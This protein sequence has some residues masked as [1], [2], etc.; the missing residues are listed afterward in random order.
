M[1]PGPVVTF[2]SATA[3]RNFVNVVGAE[4]AADLLRATEVACIGPTTAEAAAQFNIR[5]TIV[6]AQYTAGALVEAI[7]EHFA[8]GAKAGAQRA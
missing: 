8:K 7:V 2:T 3:V 4:P 1:P 6:P 5:T